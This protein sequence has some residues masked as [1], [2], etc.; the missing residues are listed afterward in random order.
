[1]ICTD[2]LAPLTAASDLPDHPT[3]AKPFLSNTLTELTRHAGGM[4]QKEKASLWRMKHLL[5]KL[6]GDHTWIPCE[7]V[8]TESDFVLLGDE[9][10]RQRGSQLQKTIS[11]SKDDGDHLSTGTLASEDESQAAPLMITQGEAPQ[12][13][14][15]D[16][17]NGANTD[18]DVIMISPTDEAT[19]PNKTGTDMSA[20][21]DDTQQVDVPKQSTEDAS[22]ERQEAPAEGAMDVDGAILLGDSAENQVQVLVAIDVDA[23]AIDDQEDLPAPTRMRTRAQAQAASENTTTRTRSATT[24]SNM[25]SFIHP[26]FLAPLKSHPDRDLGLPQHEAEE[27]RKYLQLYIQKQEEV[28]RGAQRVYEGL[29]KADRYRHLVMKWAKAE[30]HVGLNRDMSD[31][32]DWY[33]KEEWGLDEDLKKGQDEEEEDATTTAKKT[34]TRR[35]N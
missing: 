9:R 16:A 20:A 22:G 1:V 8:E 14:V 25:E 3:L 15:S 35:A 32:E 29:L 23:Q 21:L 33:D 17:G 2:L 34:R 18:G 7:N 12:E 27:T 4:V 10:D 19:V 24:D 5:T 11:I 28:C 31:G 13:G 30:A 26:Y 6:S